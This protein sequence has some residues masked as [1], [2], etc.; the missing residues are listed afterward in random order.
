MVSIYYDIYAAVFN[1]LNIQYLTTCGQK[2]SIA[3]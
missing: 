3:D 2:I 1:E